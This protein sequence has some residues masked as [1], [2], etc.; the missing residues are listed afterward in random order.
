MD[1]DYNPGAG[2][3]PARGRKSILLGTL[4]PFTSGKGKTR[5]ER[6]IGKTRLTGQSRYMLSF[7]DPV[8]LSRWGIKTAAASDARPDVQVSESRP[9][10]RQLSLLPLSQCLWLPPPFPPELPPLGVAPCDGGA[11]CEGAGRG[12]L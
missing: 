10:P 6:A 3:S 8:H 1:L 11:A 5:W 9:N 4:R 12:G 7:P 2:R